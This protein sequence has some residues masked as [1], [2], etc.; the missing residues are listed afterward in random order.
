M[1][2]LTSGIYHICDAMLSDLRSCRYGI[3]ASN[4]GAILAQGL[5]VPAG[6]PAYIADPVVVDELSSLARYSGHPDICRRSIFHA[7]NHKAVGRRGAQEL[8]RPYEKL[9]LIVA[10]LGGGTSVGAHEDGQVVDITSALDG[11]GPFSAERSGA[12]PVSRVMDWC[13]APDADE[14]EI[15]KRLTGNGGLLA[16]LGTADGLHIE[17]RIKDGDVYAQEVYTAMAYQI[18]KEISAMGAVLRGQVDA[19]ILTGGLVHDDFLVELIRE[20]VTYLG[21]VIVYAGEDEMSALAEVAFRALRGE[22]SVRMY[23]DV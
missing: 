9:K 17:Q 5:A 12:L 7:L 6:L 23:T 22:E 8:G 16:Y 20:R 1:R 14:Q 15:R 19:V 3:H 11:E 2:P 13:F 21:R 10:H 18:A 4:L